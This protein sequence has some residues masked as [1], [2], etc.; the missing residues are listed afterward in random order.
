MSG[1]VN[2][3]AWK[4]GWKPKAVIIGMFVVGAIIGALVDQAGLF[5]FLGLIAGVGLWFW[6]RNEVNDKYASELE[7]FRDRS[8]SK[9]E[10]ATAGLEAEAVH[11]FISS[12]GSSPPLIEPDSQYQASHLLFGDTSILVN[13][14]YGFDMENRKMVQGGSQNEYFYDQITGVDSENYSNYAELVINMSGGGGHTI[15][16]RDPSSINQVKSDLQQRMRDARRA[17]Q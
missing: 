17:T 1:G 7:D 14:E 2:E 10:S 13:D 5:G 11:T 15:R 3:T 4:V 8:R 6:G 16:S 9:V 12:N